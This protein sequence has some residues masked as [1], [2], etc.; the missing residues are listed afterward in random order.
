MSL[1]LRSR[2]AMRVLV[3]TA[4]GLSGCA[5]MPSA[6]PPLTVPCPRPAPLPAPVQRIDS[7]PSTSM[8]SRALQWL[9]SSE[10]VLTGET[11]R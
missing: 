5:Q 4:I 7:Q 10:Q 1:P 3:L 6:A 2:R 8:L 9:Q 11:P